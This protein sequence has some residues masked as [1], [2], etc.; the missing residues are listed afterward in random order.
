MTTHTEA[1]LEYL[2]R[3]LLAPA[4]RPRDLSDLSINCELESQPETELYRTSSDVTYHR[5]GWEQR[6]SADWR[7]FDAPASEGWLTVIDFRRVGDRLAYRYLANDDSHDRLY[8][9]WSSSKIQAFTA[10]VSA[11]REQGIGADASVGGVKLRDLITSINTYAP[12][13]DVSGDSN[14]IATYLLSAAGRDYATALFHKNWLKLANADVRLRGAYGPTTFAPPSNEFVAS[15]GTI[16]VTRSV[17]N[18]ANND[19]GYRTYRCDECGTDGNKAMTALA[20]TEWLKRLASHA[21]DSS[22]RHPGLEISDVET[23]FFG[24]QQQREGEVGGMLSGISVFLPQALARA[25]TPGA[26]DNAKDTLDAVTNGRWRIY[27][28]VGWGPSETRGTSEV[29]ML[30]H[31]CLPRVGKT[32]REFTLLAR[33]TVPGDDA[34]ESKVGEAGLKLERLLDRALPQLLR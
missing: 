33:A 15:D 24:G 13:G 26:G 5:L 31:V 2:E 22:V 23:L 34:D 27:Q 7:F 28:K 18:P 30:A 12:S 21:R 25:V 1:G 9:P 29:V 16:R 20:Q 11:L 17:Y 6:L 10:A 8:E 32:G 4:I 14:A 3:S 19:P